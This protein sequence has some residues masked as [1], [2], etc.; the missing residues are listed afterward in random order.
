[1]SPYFYPV[2][3]KEDLSRAVGLS[4]HKVSFLS[5][6]HVLLK[7]W[8]DGR[9]SQMSRD[10][11]YF[12]SISF[13]F[14]FATVSSKRRNNVNLSSDNRSN[15]IYTVSLDHLVNYILIGNRY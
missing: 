4:L 7:A 11:S 5:A 14:T 9:S 8:I 12:V 13:P 15:D 10:A 3:T 6:F 1:M 2:G